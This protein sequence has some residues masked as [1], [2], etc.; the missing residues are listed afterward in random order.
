VKF[1]LIL[2][3]EYGLNVFRLSASVSLALEKLDKVSIN[4]ESVVSSIQEDDDKF[5]LKYKQDAKLQEE[6][7]DFIINAAGF[8]SGEIDDMLGFKRQR[9]VEFKAAYVTS[10]EAKELWPEVIFHG[11]RGTPQGMAQ[12]TPY[13]DGYVQLHGMT[14]DITLFEDGLVKST[15]LSAQPKLDKKYI[16]KIDSGWSEEDTKERTSL[17]I[18]HVSNFIPTF[19]G[20]KVASQPLYGA[21]QIPGDD[22]SLRAVGVSFESS[23][24]ARCENVKAS[25]VLGMGDEIVKRLAD[26][27]MVENSNVGFRDFKSNKSFLE[28]DITSYATKLCQKRGYPDSMAKRYNSSILL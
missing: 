1:P 24:Y 12:F 21:Q 11:T 20:A 13:P 14:E 9:F 8:K 18:E 10:W 5:I 16:D 17:A 26:L 6:K 22:A 7:F 25:S 15:A 28:S 23:R 2:V 4:L 27:G 3:Q 19:K